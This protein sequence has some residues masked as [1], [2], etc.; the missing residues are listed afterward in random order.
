[1]TS[2]G[3]FGEDA[4]LLGGE[5]VE[6][7]SLELDEALDSA[8]LLQRRLGRDRAC[9]GMANEDRAVK[10][11]GEPRHVDDGRVVAGRRG[12]LLAEARN[13]G[14]DQVGDHL[15]GELL[16]V[17][18]RELFVGPGLA[19]LG[20]E[21]EDSQANSSVASSTLRCSPGG[22]LPSRTSLKPDGLKPDRPRPDC[23]AR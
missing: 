15:L 12:E 14:Q 5:V 2:I 10:L 23:S 21:A 4:D 9:L 16:N 22:S 6:A 11:L 19:H 20:A 1:M 17:I 13:L 18:D 8:H 3:I 7:S